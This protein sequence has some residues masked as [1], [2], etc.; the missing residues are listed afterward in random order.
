LYSKKRANVMPS[1]LLSTKK[2]GR[3]MWRFTLI[4]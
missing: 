4:A 3:L 2:R 1:M